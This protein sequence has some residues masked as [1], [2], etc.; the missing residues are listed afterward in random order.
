MFIKEQLSGQQL[1]RNSGFYVLR[2]LLTVLLGIVLVASVIPINFGAL[3]VWGY[4]VWCLATTRPG[5]EWCWHAGLMGV[6][7]I[8][9]ISAP[10]KVEERV[11]GRWI[12]LP[13]EELTLAEVKDPG[14]AN[15]RKPFLFY[16]NAPED[17]A[18]HVVRFP[19]RD[20]TIGQFI[21]TI[22]SQ[23][24]LRHRFHHCG[25]GWTILYGG[26]CTFGVAFR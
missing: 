10:G 8:A 17:L 4:F 25:N 7:L 20:L 2:F 18:G 12:S 24:P 9:A 22:E 5:R 26:D 14:Q 23:T 21:D 19:S 6:I 16:L 1:V 11:R 13:R 15:F 3:I